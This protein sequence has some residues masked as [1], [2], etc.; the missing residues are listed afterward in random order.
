MLRSI[1]SDSAYFISVRQVTTTLFYL[2][3][4]LFFSVVD[5]KW[6]HLIIICN[7]WSV[8]STIKLPVKNLITEAKFLFPKLMLLTIERNTYI[9]IKS[10]IKGTILY[11]YKS[12]ACVLLVSNTIESDRFVHFSHGEVYLIE[13]Y[14]IKGVSDLWQV[15]RFLWVLRFPLQIKLTV[16]I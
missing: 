1:L 9:L 8:L 12:R 2:S 10:Y 11:I 14:V 5:D 13:H 7:Y 15:N 4:L 3:L 16:M 6:K